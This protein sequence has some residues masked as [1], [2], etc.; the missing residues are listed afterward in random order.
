MTAAQ[1][2]KIPEHLRAAADA[3]NMADEAIMK[4]DPR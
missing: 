4:L 2:S 1:A 3:I